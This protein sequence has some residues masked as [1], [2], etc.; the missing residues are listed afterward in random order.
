MSIGLLRQD[1]YEAD[2]GIVFGCRYYRLNGKEIL[3]LIQATSGK[4]NHSVFYFAN[5]NEI[6]EIYQWQQR[7]NLKYPMKEEGSYSRVLFP[8]P[9]LKVKIANQENVSVSVLQDY[10]PRSKELQESLWRNKVKQHDSITQ[11]MVHLLTGRLSPTLEQLEE[12]KDYFDSDLTN[13]SEKISDAVKSRNHAPTT[14]AQPIK[15][16]SESEEVYKHLFHSLKKLANQNDKHFQS[17]YPKLRTMSTNI[18]K[19]FQAIG[20][21]AYLSLYIKDYDNN[22]IIKQNSKEDNQRSR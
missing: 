1:Y 13:L 10:F 9:G 5:P 19:G 3:E 12:T 8:P 20:P 6:K 15:I 17:I 16:E 21:E 7:E 14:P 4:A 22:Q 11:V 18:A 2:N